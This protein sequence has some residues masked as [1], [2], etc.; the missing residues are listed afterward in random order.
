MYIVRVMAN[1]SNP[2]NN[3][4]NEDELTDD[5]EPE[6]MTLFEARCI[7]NRARKVYK[8]FEIDQETLAT[9]EEKVSALESGQYNGLCRYYPKCQARN[10]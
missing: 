6:D 7:L 4:L 8:S 3:L 1:P 10:S 2:L 5:V 9:E